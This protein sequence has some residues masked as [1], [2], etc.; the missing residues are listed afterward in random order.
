MASDMEARIQ[1]NKN[2]SKII[3][4]SYSRLD[5]GWDELTDVDWENLGG[6]GSLPMR[7]WSSR[8][9]LAAGNT[10]DCHIV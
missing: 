10:W 3:H 2:W 5:A 9:A 6:F 1:L 8:C 4:W 7:I